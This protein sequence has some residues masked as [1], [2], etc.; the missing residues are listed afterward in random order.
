MNRTGRI[1]RPGAVKH[2][3]IPIELR[4][5]AVEYGRLSRAGE[6]VPDEIRI[7]HNEYKRWA[8]R[9]GKDPEVY[10]SRIKHDYIPDDLRQAGLEYNRILR[11]GEMP[12]EDIIKKN[13]EY[14][15]WV[16]H[17]GPPPPKP[18][19]PEWPRSAHL[20][21]IRLIG[22]G[23]PPGKIPADI[24]K[25]RSEY[26]GTTLRKYTKCSPSKNRG[27]RGCRGMHGDGPRKIPYG[28]GIAMCTN[29][30]VMYQNVPDD[31]T[32]CG[33]CGKTLRRSARS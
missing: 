13:S 31:V 27:G 12:T 10:R 7:M 28:P 1:E 15:R 14:C 19:K 25:G 3:D 9:G 2:V 17:R 5:A 4:R 20:E 33:C 6:T 8:C 30:S 29:C 26:L 22:D 23:V 21:W 24:A 11:R 18:E 16:R 32:G